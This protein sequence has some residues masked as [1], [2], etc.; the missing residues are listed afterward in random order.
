MVQIK[1]EQE[2]DVV[3]KMSAENGVYFIDVPQTF[4]FD[5]NFVRTQDKNYDLESV[6]WDFNGSGTYDQKGKKMKQNFFEEQK[7]T[8]IARYTFTNILTRQKQDVTE[9]F[10]FDG[11]KQDVAPRLEVTQ[12]SP[13][14]PSRVRFDGSASQVRNGEIMEYLFDFG[15]GKGEIKGD[16]VQSYL[17]SAPGEYTVTFT[18]VKTDGTRENIKKK[19]IVKTKSQQK[20]SITPSLST[21][22]AGG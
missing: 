1:D 18:V 10:I 6:A 17:Y 14:A 15:V 9:M 16:A 2:Q 20:M 8:V 4:T 19:V 11:R 13:Y 21:S 5:A 7:Y 3:S 12:D 22:Q